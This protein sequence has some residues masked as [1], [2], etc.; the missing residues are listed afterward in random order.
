MISH[1]YKSIFVHIPKTA[2]QSISDVFLRLSG[3]NWGTCDQLLIMDNNDPAKGPARLTHLTASEYVSYG[4][5]TKKEFNTYFK[6]SFVRNPWARIVSEYKFRQFPRECDFKT[7]LFKRFPKPGW[8]DEYTHV[9][10]QYD[11]LYDSNGVK[12]VDFIGKYETLQDDFNIIC[13][14]VGI[15]RTLLGRVNQ[16]LDFKRIPISMK[17]IISGIRTLAF[18]KKINKNTFD[19]YTKYYDNETKE[20]VAEYFKKDIEAFGYTFNGK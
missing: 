7:F 1:K 5:V 20:F 14:K 12:L 13:D 17:Q 10:P 15:K 19:H 16:S 8:G 2:G 18:Y 9:L 11:F 6:F 3:F 4:Y